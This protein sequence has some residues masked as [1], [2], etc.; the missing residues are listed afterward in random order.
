[1]I[2]PQ[3]QDYDRTNSCHITVEQF[4]RV[5]KELNLIPPKEELFQILIRKYLDK[6]NIREINY[7]KFCADID[8]PEDIFVQYEDKHPVEEQPIFHGQLRDAGSTFFQSGTENLDVINNRFMQKR[9]EVSNN[10]DDIIKR[11]QHAIV[12]KRVRVEEFF[13]DFDKLRK[14]QVGEAAVSNY[15]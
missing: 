11:L 7:F 15:F 14:G 4:R 13:I 2:K 6:G 9:I 12:M 5:M 10:P 1:M 8:I 3:F